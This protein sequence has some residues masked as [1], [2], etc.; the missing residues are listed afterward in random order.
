MCL[1]HAAIAAT[2]FA[3]TTAQA[4]S[5]S[6]RA[7]GPDWFKVLN[8]DR[9]WNI[10]LEG[11]IDTGAPAR[12]A[13]ALRQAGSDG[14]DV[15][16]SS[17]GGNLLAGMQ[18]GRLI[19]QT[20]G[21]THIGTLAADP[22][23]TFGGKPGVKRVPG[24]CLSACS[25]AFLGGVYRYATKGSEYGVHRFSSSSGPLESDLDTGQIVAATVAAY[26]REMEVDPAL[27]DLMVR[28]GKDRILTLSNA[29][30]T[31][32]NVINNG[33]RTPEWSIDVVEGG[34]YLRG[35]QQT[36]YGQG[37]AVL[38]C[39]NGRIHYQSYYRVGEE[40]AKSLASGGWY[41]SLLVGNTTL[42]L[43][44][45]G[46]A[47]ATGDEIATHF[48]LTQDQAMAIASSPSMGHAMQLSREAPTFLGYR[49]DIPESASK[50]VSTFIRNCFRP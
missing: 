9:S 43:P 50:K 16:I 5:M 45:P 23:N 39:D 21:N 27:F 37:K 15:F 26:I 33:R 18:I 24:R 22:S 42:P 20:G 48:S 41:H 14:A 38:F 30:L 49:I 28:E 10:V 36:V 29:E 46:L 31:R 35:L 19:R 1:C 2:L 34:Q 47:I 25:L 7:E 6:V 40:K 3:G 12:V 32:L 17:P 13:E 8:L 44:A 4:G 11:E